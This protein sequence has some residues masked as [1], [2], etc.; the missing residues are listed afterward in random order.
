MLRADRLLGVNPDL[1]ERYVRLGLRAQ[2]QSRATLEALAAVK[3]P[4][5]VMAHLAQVS[6]G[7][8]VNNLVATLGP[9]RLRD[10]NLEN[11]R[12]ELLEADVESVDGCPPSASVSSDQTLAPVG[13][14]DR[15]EN[16]G[17]EGPVKPKRLSRK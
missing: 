10:D 9:R 7:P 14:I 1:M 4:P 15:S 11:R 3:N 12:N 17:R 16:R 8:Q 5:T 13:F 6:H 2:G